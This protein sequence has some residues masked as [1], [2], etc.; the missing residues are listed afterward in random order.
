MTIHPI[1]RYPDP[2]LAAPCHLVEV[3]DEELK[4]LVQDLLETM[5]A[6]PG[7]GITAAH[8][9]ISKR[10]S[11]IALDPGEPVHIHINPQILWSSTDRQRFIEGSVAMPGMTEEVDRPAKIRFRY[12]GLD[13]VAQEAEADGFLA[14]CIQHEV[15]QL[16]GVFWLKRLSRLKRDRLIRK[17]EKSAR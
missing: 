14:T 5:K 8:I 2:R 17:W 12:Q 7:V 13:G 16:D 15:D 9:G 4:S 3:F 6:A 11:V 10:V 1:L